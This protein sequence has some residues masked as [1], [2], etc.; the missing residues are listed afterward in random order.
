MLTR[1]SCL[2]A[3]LFAINGF[4]FAQATAEINGRVVDQGQAVAPGVNV[5]VTNAGSGA[6]R[7]SVTNA[8][9]LYSVPAL[10][11]GNYNVK[12]ELKGFSP[13]ERNVELQIGGVLTVDLQLTVGA[14]QQSVSVEAQAELIES[15]QGTIA[16]SIR[17]QEVQELP[18]SNRSMGQLMSMM[19]GAREV[20]MTSVAG[21]HGS[22][23]VQVSFGGGAGGNYNM[24]VDGVDNKE[25]HCGGAALVY[26][27]E[28]IQ[29]FKSMTTG[30]SAEYG[31]GAATVLIATKS[32]TNQVHGTAFLFNRNQ[33]LEKIDYFSDPA[34]GG[35]GKPPL[36]RY[37]YGGSVGG[38]IIKD[39]LWYF[40]SVEKIQ[41][42]FQ[43]PRPSLYLTQFGYLAN[44]N[45]GIYPPLDISYSGSLPQ[46][47]TDLLI[48]GKINYQLS[49][50]NTAF[51]RGSS[52][53][54][55][56]NNSFY[57]TKT[58]LLSYAPNHSDQ[59]NQFLPDIA[60]GET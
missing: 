11:P 29:E 18:M 41:Q 17:T 23:G 53:R 46:N 59:N 35:L 31:K 57:S 50:N 39:K 30:S 28:G 10:T 38:A 14:V 49:P 32:G 22:S 12:A 47:S 48:L 7:T 1:L 43:T 20:P 25:D 45:T 56:T 19:P 60:M 27:L 24:Q 44:L 55:Y 40:G 13:V 37:Q 26:S 6:V 42:D 33:D 2:L 36:S 21:G 51:L 58:A 8:E 54:G 5:T 16:G 34:H 3:V 9:G 52:E 15:T 4:V